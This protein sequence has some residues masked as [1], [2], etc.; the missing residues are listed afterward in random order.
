[1]EASGHADRQAARPHALAPGVQ[2]TLRRPWH[3]RR[4]P[5]I[6]R[7]RV[8]GGWEVEVRT[9]LGTPLHLVLPARA[10]RRD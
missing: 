4:T 7:R 5:A 9:A 8:L 1:V 2:V 10:L 3:L 6:V